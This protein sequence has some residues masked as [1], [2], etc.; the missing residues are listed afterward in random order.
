ML[1]ARSALAAP[2]PRPSWATTRLQLSPEEYF[3]REPEGL[4]QPTASRS[5]AETFCTPE[6]ILWCK[7]RA[8]SASER[9]VRRCFF[10]SPAI[11]ILTPILSISLLLQHLLLR[12]II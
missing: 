8:T 12:L 9:L 5:P 10:Q 6:Q 2:R 3:Q 4:P 11:L 1:W 7:I